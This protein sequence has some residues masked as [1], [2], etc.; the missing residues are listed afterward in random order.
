[1]K[2]NRI[3]KIIHYCWFGSSELNKE[4]EECIASWRE[5]CPDYEIKRWDESNYDVTVNKYMHDAWLNKKWAF[6][7]DYAR[8]DVIH[9]YGGIYLDTDVELIKP[10][11]DLLE[12][13]A[14]AGMEKPG[15][16][17]FG[18]GFGARKGNS[19]VKEI[20]D[21]YE[22]MEFVNKD[23]TLN[24]IPCPEIQTR[25]LKRHGFKESDENQVIEGMKI[26]EVKY[27]CP[28]DYDTCKLNIEK[29]TYSIH[30]YAASWS[31]PRQKIN[32]KVNKLRLELN[33]TFL[34]VFVKKAIIF[35]YKH[36]L[37][38]LKSHL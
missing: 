12:Y 34:P 32:R 4:A 22:K 11:D 36:L 29:E 26:F 10:I 13:D 23:G 16:V 33:N 35:I 19:L 28:L 31:S 25:V 27:F 5:F 37:K 17:A 18:L 30:R 20:M 21:E 9:R 8:L 15:R 6:V 3:P 38:L 1:M 7:S 14:F 2:W 24:T